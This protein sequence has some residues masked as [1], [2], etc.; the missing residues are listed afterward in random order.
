[1]ILI[2]AIKHKKEKILKKEKELKMI[3]KIKLKGF[4]FVDAVKNTVILKYWINI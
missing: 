4:K 2:I 3:K 1:M